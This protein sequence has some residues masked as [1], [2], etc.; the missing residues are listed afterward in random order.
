M[1][2]TLPDVV[3]FLGL[4]LASISDLRTQ[5]I[6]NPLNF[7]LMAAGLL[8]HGLAL[9][10]W[11]PITGILAGFALHFTL[12]VLGVERGGDAKLFMGV[13]ALLGPWLMLEATIWTYA[14]FLPV[15]IIVIIL[16]GK[17]RNFLETVRYAYRRALRYPVEPPEEQTYMALGPVIAVG[18]I[19]ARFTDLLPF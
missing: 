19:V 13:G 5:K 6:P 12:W 9:D 15:G 4:L 8:I 11:L 18:T 17:L 14:L 3:L 16:R 10:P 1:E 2:L 7:S